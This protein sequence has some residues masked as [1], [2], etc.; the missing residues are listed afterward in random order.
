MHYPSRKLRH[1]AGAVLATILVSA[2]LA[3]HAVEWPQAIDAPEGQIVVYQPQPEALEGNTLTGRS[4]MSLELNNSD[5]PIFGVFWFEATIDTD[6]DTGSALVR[7]LRVTRV[8]WPDSTDAQEQRFTRIVE[9]AIPEN[10]FEISMERLT[11]SLAAAEREQRSLAELKHDPPKILFSRELA[12]LLL[13]D[14]QPRFSDVENS[15]YERAL[16]TPFAVVRDKRSKRVYLSSGQL[17]YEAR[18]PL[19]PFAATTSPPADL[20]QMM[21]PPDTSEPAP[22]VPPAVFVATEPTEL[23][24]TQGD[25]EWTPLTGGQLLYVSNTETPWLRELST[26][27]MYVLLSGRWY[28]AR[29]E[30]GAWTFV[31]AN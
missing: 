5:A 10:G 16:N 15:G 7:N 25:P 18:D 14:G 13:Y 21:P 24:A 12:V 1:K 22:A 26:G 4:A 20:V 23:I 2:S 30:A 9:D 31:P 29:A 27:N 3:A 8:G 28:R 11:A 17:W 6:R 19:G